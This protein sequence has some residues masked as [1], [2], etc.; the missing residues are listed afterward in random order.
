M[1]TNL[2]VKY[3]LA[4]QLWEASPSQ[5]IFPL[6]GSGFFR[7]SELVSPRVPEFRG[8]GDPITAS[9]GMEALLG[10]KACGCGGERLVATE[11]K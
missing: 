3:I 8:C 10:R 2:R 1:L 6:L 7:L 9:L 11:L 5:S 4:P